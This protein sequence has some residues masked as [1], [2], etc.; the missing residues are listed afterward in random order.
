MKMKAITLI[1]ISLMSI[2]GVHAR[3]VFMQEFVCP[4]GGQKFSTQMDGSGTSFGQMLDFKPIGPMPAPWTLAVCPDNQFVI[5]K[6]DFTEEELKILTP[7]VESA[8]YKKIINTPTYYRAAQL[9]RVLKEPTG[10]IAT[11][12]LQATWQSPTVPYQKEALAEYNKYIDELA[13]NQSTAQ[14]FENARWVN[15]NLIALELERR[16]GQFDAAKQRLN[17]LSISNDFKED[18]Q[19]IKQILT[20]Q[21]KLIDQKDQNGHRVIDESE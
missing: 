1:L 2:T 15:A 21:K 7:Y 14:L 11:T 6:D 9:Q 17:A 18:D 8:E 12:L 19:F 20:L 10:D 5:F 16:T 4:I 3:T 13:Q